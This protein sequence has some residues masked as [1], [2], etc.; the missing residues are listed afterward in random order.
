MVTTLVDVAS[1][2]PSNEYSELAPEEYTIRRLLQGVP[3][4]VDD[5]WPEQALPLESNLDYMNGGK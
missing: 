3:E 2:L 1:I 5:I 4:G